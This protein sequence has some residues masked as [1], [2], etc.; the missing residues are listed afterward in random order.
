M[1]R[2]F[3][4]T[5]AVM[6]FGLHLCSLFS[7]PEAQIRN[8]VGR[9]MPADAVPSGQQVFR[10]MNAEPT[11]LDIGVAIYEVGGIVFLFERLTMLDYNNRVIPGAAESWEASDDQTRWTFHMRPD[12]RWS[13]GRP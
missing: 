8:A 1:Q 3:F 13:D 7:E 12:G 6:V 4:W 5:V 9:I 10:F 2:T 11:N